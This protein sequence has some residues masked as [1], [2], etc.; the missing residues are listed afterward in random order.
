MKDDRN[1]AQEHLELLA[2][3]LGKAAIENGFAVSIEFKR[4]VEL[5]YQ[6]F[7]VKEMMDIFM[8]MAKQ[9]QAATQ[10]QALDGFGMTEK[11]Q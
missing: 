11:G 10:F 9:Q 4:L 7:D 1:V 3:E 2:K 6:N 5:P 8:D